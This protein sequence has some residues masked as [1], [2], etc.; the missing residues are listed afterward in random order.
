MQ[1]DYDENRPE[2]TELCTACHKDTFFSHRGDKGQS[3]RFGA[4]IMLE[5]R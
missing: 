1:L 5:D 2:E 4:F 3:G